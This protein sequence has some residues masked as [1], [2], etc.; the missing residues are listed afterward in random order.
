MTE[1]ITE[2][3]LW[4][5]VM[6]L[7]IAFGAGLYEQRIILPQWFSRSPESGLR[8][9]SEAMRRTDAGLKFWAYVTTV[10]LTF[11]TLTSLAVAWQTQ[12][13]RYDWWLAATAIIL[14]ERIGTF[15]YFI[16]TAL[17]LMRAES[18]PQSRVDTMASQ[19]ARLNYI[20]ASLTLAVW[21]A[22]LEAFSIPVEP[23]GLIVN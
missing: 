13:P 4:L 8:V 11:L 1:Y 16:P 18:L 3:L 22:A 20:R 6:N 21:I 5:F 14:V 2:A 19:W 7:G 12:G 23:G 15:S 17:K 10:P 9:D